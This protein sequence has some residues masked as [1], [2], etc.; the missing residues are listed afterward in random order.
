MISVDGGGAEDS[1]I[2]RIRSGW[3]KFNRDLLYLSWLDCRGFLSLEGC[4][5]SVMQYGSETWA[6][7]EANF[8]RLECTVTKLA[9]SLSAGF[10]LTQNI[11]YFTQKNIL[12]RKKWNAMH[13]WDAQDWQE[14]TV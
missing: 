1:V 11:A 9:G 10:S 2:A 14:I 13:P 3:K 6:V 4:A 5:R 7:K 12:G 8:L